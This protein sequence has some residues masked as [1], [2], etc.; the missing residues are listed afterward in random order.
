M[1]KVN[2]AAEWLGI[3]NYGEHSMLVYSSLEE[4]REIY[5]RYCRIALE[6]ND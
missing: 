5:S 6:K 1:M 2:S 4:F 3:S